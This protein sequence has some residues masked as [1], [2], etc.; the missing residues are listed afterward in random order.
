MS[1]PTER[2]RFLREQLKEAVGSYPQDLCEKSLRAML[3]SSGI[4]PDV[5]T[6]LLRCVE[7]TAYMAMLADE[8]FQSSFQNEGSFCRDEFL[9][10]YRERLAKAIPIA[11]GIVAAK[12]TGNPALTIQADPTRSLQ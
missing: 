10:I 12:F 11:A 8:K 4:D 7:G 9:R 6:R 3:D 1:E 2:E 5:W